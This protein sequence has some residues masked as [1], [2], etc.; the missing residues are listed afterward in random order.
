MMPLIRLHRLK[1]KN[2]LSPRSKVPAR[3]VARSS[4]AI[5]PHELKFEAGQRE[6]QEGREEF[7]IS[8][9]YCN[10]IALRLALSLGERRECHGLR[11]TGGS[12]AFT[13]ERL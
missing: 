1:S 3:L 12:I 8:Y 10:S 6:Y 2:I 7:G 4:V 5:Q 11:R 9:L 13:A